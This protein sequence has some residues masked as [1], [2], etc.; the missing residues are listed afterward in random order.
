MNIVDLDQPERRT[1]QAPK[2]KIAT[3]TGVI[4]TKLHPYLDSIDHL[5]SA[6]PLYGSHLDS[7]V[8][9]YA[10]SAAEWADEMTFDL[11]HAHDW[12]TSLAAME[13]RKRTGKPIVLHLHSLSYD[14]S[15]PASKGWINEIEKNA[16][17]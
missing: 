6:G 15:G 1:K 4:P 17:P 12:M 3:K 9:S 7:H 16:I 8:M 5:P 2:L 13:I 11:I 14:R 10:R